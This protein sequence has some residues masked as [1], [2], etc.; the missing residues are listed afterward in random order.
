MDLG[1]VALV[2]TPD[3]LIAAIRNLQ[4]ETGG[5]TESTSYHEIGPVSPADVAMRACM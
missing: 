1:G 3:D 5:F 2:G 4:Q